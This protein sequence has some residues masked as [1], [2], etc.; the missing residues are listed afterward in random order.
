MVQCNFQY[1]HFINYQ[2]QLELNMLWSEFQFSN[3]PTQFGALNLFDWFDT[4]GSFD[5]FHSFDWFDAFDSFDSFPFDWPHVSSHRATWFVK[6]ILS[7]KIVKWIFR[8]SQIMFESI[9]SNGSIHSIVWSK[10]RNA[11]H[12]FSRFTRYMY[13]RL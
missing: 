12:W 8:I 5:W 3:H 2:H 6:Y 1:I 7:I 9:Y 13:R 10:S 11:N 4:I